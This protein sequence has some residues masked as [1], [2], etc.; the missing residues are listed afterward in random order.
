[1]GVL[2]AMVGAEQLVAVVDEEEEEEGACGGWGACAMHAQRMRS[3]GQVGWVPW[4]LGFRSAHGFRTVRRPSPMQHGPYVR[5]AGASVRGPRGGD[6]CGPYMAT[7]MGL[8]WRQMALRLGTREGMRGACAPPARRL[9]R[10]RAAAG[11]HVWASCV[12]LMCGVRSSKAGRAAALR[13]TAVGPCGPYM[14]GAAVRALRQ[15]RTV[16][17]HTQ[18]SAA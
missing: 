7:N 1:M 11:P 14:R 16:H 5:P 2:R 15:G 6:K 17:V 8:I 4:V 12:G 10:R 13:R 3:A 18:H 9:Y